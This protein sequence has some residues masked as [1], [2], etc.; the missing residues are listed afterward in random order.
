VTT[1]G[2][3]SSASQSSP[4][5]CVNLLLQREKAIQRL[6]MEHQ[7]LA[8]QCA[9][10]G[11]QAVTCRVA[12]GSWRRYASVARNLSI[13]SALGPSGVTRGADTQVS[14]QEALA[15]L[16]TRHQRLQAL[17]RVAVITDYVPQ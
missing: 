16:H 10:V 11:L 9:T 5:D 1:M 3:Y 2:P 6:E 15:S 4:A 17:A 13:P 8:V 12:D 14:F 7:R